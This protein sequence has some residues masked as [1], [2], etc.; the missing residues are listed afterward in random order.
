MLTICFYLPPEEL[1]RGIG[2]ASDVRPARSLADRISFLEQ[3]SETHGGDF[4]HIARTHPLGGVD[5][6]FVVYE[7]CPT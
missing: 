7:F 3:I 2:V 5:V 6:P 4:F 1:G